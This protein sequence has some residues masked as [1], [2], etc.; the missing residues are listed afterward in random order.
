MPPVYHGKC[1]K[2]FYVGE[3]ALSVYISPGSTVF[4]TTGAVTVPCSS[5][6]EELEHSV[7]NPG[8]S[9]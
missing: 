5:G 6:R 2:E 8:P 7:T 3:V 1:I 9:P 4:S